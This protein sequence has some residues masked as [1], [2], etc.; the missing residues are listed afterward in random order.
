[1]TTTEN[2]I[3]VVIV[4]DHALY[5][6]GISSTIET[7][8]DSIEV[9][10]ECSSGAEFYALLE[11]GII[12]S[13]VLLDIFLPDTTGI[14]IARY[15]KRKFPEIKIIVLSS[16]VTED[17]VSELLE[18]NVEGYLSKLALMSD[19]E[20]AIQ[21]VLSDDHYYG[22]SVAKIMYGVFVAKNNQPPKKKGLFSRKE[23][24]ALTNREIEIVRLLCDGFQ[25][26][27]IADKLNT[28][29]RTIETH[30][31]NILKKMGFNNIAEVIKYAV[32]NKIVEWE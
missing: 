8:A 21:T 5:R 14:E 22:Q 6:M 31:A 15:L 10:A 17:T 9:I 19:L 28:S 32:K 11:I 27:E 25:A 7:L 29:V 16:E 23:D 30:K 24:P 18:I 4:D 13:V 20:K 1:M 12:P 2:T 26:K 3:S